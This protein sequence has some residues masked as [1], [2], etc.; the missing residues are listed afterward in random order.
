MDT[1]RL[2]MLALCL[3][4]IAGCGGGGGAPGTG[5]GGT[6]GGG[7]GGG[8]TGGSGG[9]GGTPPYKHP[10]ANTTLTDPT[11]LPTTGTASYSGLMALSF[12]T[13]AN[14]PGRTTAHAGDLAASVNFAA[15][16]VTGTVRNVAAG[17][18]PA[19]LGV[20]YL[21]L[22]AIDRAATGTDP[23]YA[24]LLSGTL[25]EGD[26]SYLLHGTFTGDF[27][28]TTPA[29]MAGKVS[30]ETIRTGRTSAFSGTFRAS[31]P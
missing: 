17:T 27:V 19:M 6:G 4:V 29:E 7:T 23:T 22:G 14:A 10:L 5:G 24:G 31:G 15:G 9:G 3:S 20:L 26:N 2:A 28:G 8:G 25:K 1:P 21:T 16:S 12:E 11:R 30:G 18:A 13:V